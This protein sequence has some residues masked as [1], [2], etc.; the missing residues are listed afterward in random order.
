MYNPASRNTWQMNYTMGHNYFGKSVAHV[1]RPVSVNSEQ[2]FAQGI[3]NIR[4]D[5]A[6]QY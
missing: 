6:K 2:Y 5:F 1:F 4:T 3:F